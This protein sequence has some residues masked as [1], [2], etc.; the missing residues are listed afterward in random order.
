MA[1]KRDSNFAGG[2]SSACLKTQLKNWAPAFGTSS[3]SGPPL[4]V[5][6]MVVGLRPRAATALWPR[7]PGPGSIPL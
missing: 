6:P 5:L 4:R 2:G 7:G 3:P 1:Y